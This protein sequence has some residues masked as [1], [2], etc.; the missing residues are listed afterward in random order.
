MYQRLPCPAVGSSVKA[1]QVASGKMH[2]GP[3]YCPGAVE[4][5]RT[6][7]QLGHGVL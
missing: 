1:A 4:A 6:F 5:Y 3:W 2:V 7:N